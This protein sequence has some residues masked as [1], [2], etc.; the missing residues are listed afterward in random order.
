M[1]AFA[2]R[3]AN[4]L[5]GNGDGA[6][7]LELG[8]GPVAFELAQTGLLAVAGS[9]VRVTLDGRA[10]P[11]WMAFLARRGQVVEIAQG[12]GGCWAYIAIAGGIEVP[13]VLGSRATYLPG[14]FGGLAG[15][16]LQV[17]DALPVGPTTIDLLQWAGASI[18]AEARPPYAQH[19]TLPVIFGPQANH[20]TPEAR[21]TFC[22]AVYQVSHTA[23]RIGYRLTGQALAHA[24]SA[25]ILSEGVA[26]GAVQVPADGQPLVM[27][28]DRPTTGGYA[29]IATLAS[30]ALP[31]LVQCEPGQ[32]QVRFQPIA[33]AAAQRQYRQ[34]LA[35]LWPQ[36]VE[37]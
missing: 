20:F 26:L 12:A 27:L 8:G 37:D 7:A 31:L 9:G 21:A 4:R 24:R 30:V 23:N 32:G 15:R 25:D 22:A 10:V 2:L 34:Q 18:P 33:L 16:C 1:D 14:A 11:N 35:A 6:A 36:F 13:L 17:G 5:V 3:A 19:P 28:A 29:K